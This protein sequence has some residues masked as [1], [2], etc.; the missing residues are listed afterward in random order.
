MFPIIQ[1]RR[2]VF[3][4]AIQNYN[5]EDTQKYNFASFCIG[6]ELVDHFEGGQ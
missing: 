5:A 2:F 1:C 4:S 6:V 3:H